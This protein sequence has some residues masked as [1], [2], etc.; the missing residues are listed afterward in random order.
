MFFRVLAIFISFTGYFR[1]PFRSAKRN[2][3]FFCRVVTTEGEIFSDP[4]PPRKK[5]R[6]VAFL[7]WIRIPMENIYRKKKTDG[8]GKSVVSQRPETPSHLTL[9][10][11][12]SHNIHHIIY[13]GNIVINRRND[14]VKL[15]AI[16]T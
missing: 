6:K 9:F 2:V 1:V 13:D 11:H 10:E 12:A 15:Y 8:L 4:P 14:L 7:L 16:G 3:A 5:A